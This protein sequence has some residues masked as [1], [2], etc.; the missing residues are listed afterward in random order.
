[1]KINFDYQVFC[2][3]EYGGISRYFFEIA[4]KLKNNYKQDVT[5]I[6]PLY[7]NNYLKGEFN[8]FNLIGIPFRPIPKTGRIIR[9]LNSLLAKPLLAYSKPDIVHE[10]YY[11]DRRSTPRGSKTIVT[12]H[13]MIHEKFSDQF[14]ARD[15]TSHKKKL[16]IQ[17]AD[18]VIC[19]SENTRRDLI[20]LF[21]VKPENTSVVYHGFTL[22]HKGGGIKADS[23]NRPFLLYVGVRNGYKNFD[24]LLQ[25]YASSFVLKNNFDLV[26]F[27]GGPFSDNEHLLMQKYKLASG[28]VRQVS[29]N[30]T[31]L[32]TCY[33]SASVF[34]YP[35]LYEGFGIPPLEAMS[36]NCPVVCSNVSSIPE[37]VG[38][39]AEMFD[40]Y[41]LD[42]MRTAIE[43]VVSDSDLRSELIAK[44]QERIKL[45]SWLQCAKETLDVYLKVL[46]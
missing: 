20:E 22:N 27:G 35:S 42:S 12:V 45:F 26:C 9:G 24:T 5:V 3:Q 40:P 7:I 28:R 39:G 29:G 14:P 1:M 33:R 43:R 41:Q 19:V 10:T 25:A 4:N 46:S 13:D 32:A 16:A 30:D 31:L 36:F 15:K 17:R 44:G 21:D 8:Y 34:V 37:V 2:S 6:S 11:S 18:H 38:E 23:F